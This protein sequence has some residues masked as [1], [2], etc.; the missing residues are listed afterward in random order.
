MKKLIANAMTPEILGLNYY[1]EENARITMLNR[2]LCNL[3]EK[4]LKNRSFYKLEAE[5]LL[6]KAQGNFPR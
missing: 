2:E 3:L 1:V 5:E 6:A 4:M